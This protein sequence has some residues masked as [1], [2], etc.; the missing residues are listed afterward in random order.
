MSKDDL[1]KVLFRNIVRACSFKNVKE[2]LLRLYPEQKN[3]INGYKDVFET[4]CLMR[5]RYNKEGMVIDIKRI[6]RGKNAY[7][8]VSG[9]CIEK[10][11]QQSYAL[12]YTSW[13][14]WLGYEVAKSV[15]KKMPKDEIVA[16]CLWEMTFA[17]FTQE[18]IWR[19]ISALK[20]QTRD[21]KEGKVKTI[22]FE[23][24]RASIKAKTKVKKP[25]SEQWLY[26]NKKALDSVQRG[27]KQAAKGKV[28]KLNLNEL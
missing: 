13:S 28:T 7:F 22:P 11:T 6:C 21:I 17:G 27:L 12:E 23:E 9:I 24:V 15:L 2:S 19:K 20:K 3:N 25:S 10:D 4:L 16:H 1:E 14:N 26:K 5:P 18:K 8:A